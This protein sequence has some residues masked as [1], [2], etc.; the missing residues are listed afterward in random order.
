MN[1]W[2]FPLVYYGDLHLNQKILIHFYGSI[3]V[4]LYVMYKLSFVCCISFLD[5]KFSRHLHRS[6]LC[7]QDHRKDM[8]SWSM[9]RVSSRC[10]MSLKWLRLLTYCNWSQISDLVGYIHFKRRTQDFWC[11]ILCV[12]YFNPLPLGWT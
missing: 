3:G 2:D 8:R 12:L 11:L 10:T 1:P 6:Q 5:Y 4:A 7:P 9:A